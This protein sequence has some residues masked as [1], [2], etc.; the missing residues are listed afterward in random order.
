[1]TTIFVA[2]N[3]LIIMNQEKVLTQFAQIVAQWEQSLEKYT[4]NELEQKPSAE[5]WSI[6]Q[7]Y[8]HL[9]NSALYFHIKQIEACVASPANSQGSKTF[10][11][12]LAFYVL[13]AF[14]PIK[15]QVPASESYTPKQPKDKAEIQQGLAQVKQ[16]MQEIPL[17]LKNNAGGKTTHPAFGYLG[18]EE[19]FKLIDMHYRHHLRQQKRLDLFL[20]KG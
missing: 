13:G 15:V 4:P 5:A 9:V 12:I 8:M 2:T 11:G 17:L 20:N 7:M 3:Y 6:G 10:K 19:W 18:A 14:P 16:K 1:M